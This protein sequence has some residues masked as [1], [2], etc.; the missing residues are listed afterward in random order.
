VP[1]QNAPI[2][3]CLGGGFRGAGA[4]KRRRTLVPDLLRF[5]GKS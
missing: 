4:S 2:T 5:A 3:Y 1:V